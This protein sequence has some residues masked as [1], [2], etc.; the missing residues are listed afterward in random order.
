MPA[1]Y[2]GA[3]ANAFLRKRA[4]AAAKLRKPFIVQGVGMVREHCSPMHSPWQVLLRLAEADSAHW[5]FDATSI[6]A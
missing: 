2:A 5:C 1:Q 3:F 4:R 6:S